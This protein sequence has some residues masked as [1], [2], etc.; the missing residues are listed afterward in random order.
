MGTPKTQASYRTISIDD[1]LTEELRTHKKRQIENR[2]RYGK[3][4]YDST[5]V[6]TK[7]NGEP[8]T[9]NSIKWSANKIK[10]ILD[11]ISIHLDTP[12]QLCF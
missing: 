4:Y 5:F 10:K 2:M 8:V 3:F 9:L 6:C 7:E 1:M 11:S 12:M